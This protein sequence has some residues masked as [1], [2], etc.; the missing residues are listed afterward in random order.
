[1]EGVGFLNDI[2]EHSLPSVHLR[3]KE[4]KINFYYAK[5]RSLKDFSLLN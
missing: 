2:P 3:L 4:G 1:M 5:T